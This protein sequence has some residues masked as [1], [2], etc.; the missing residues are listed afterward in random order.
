MKKNLV[1]DQ[2]F[3]GIDFSLKL[4]EKS[5]YEYCQFIACNLTEQD[6]TNISFLE[7][8]F[9]DCDLSSVKLLNTGLKDI[10]FKNCKMLGLHF[11]QCSTFL[12]NMTYTDCQLDLSSFY[13][14]PLKQTSFTNCSLKEV[15]FVETDLTESTFKDCDLTGS[16]FESSIL[17]KVD[18]STAFNYIID[19]EINQIKGAK[20]SISGLIGLLQKHNI[21]VI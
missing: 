12:L 17:N 18:F 21:K 4:F 14:L 9:V 5:D 10:Q 11:D 20:F 8:E 16:V 2:I 15:D 6:L 3:K 7:C 1:E 13:Q 19:P